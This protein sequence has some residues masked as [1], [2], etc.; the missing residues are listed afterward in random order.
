MQGV[1]HSNI[2][3]CSCVACGSMACRVPFL[4]GF[5]ALLVPSGG[6]R[7]ANRAVAN[8]KDQRPA[9]TR[10]HVPQHRRVLQ[11]PLGC[12]PSRSALTMPV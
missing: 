3:A 12:S 2:N 9:A 10:N 7:A 8:L 6:A 4:C 5:V 1:Q 11:V